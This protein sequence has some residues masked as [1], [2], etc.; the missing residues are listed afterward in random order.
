L[1]SNKRF[2]D[3]TKLSRSKELLKYYNKSCRRDPV[4]GFY[5]ITADN[6]DPIMKQIT[7]QYVQKEFILDIAYSEVQIL[8]DLPY[9][10]NS[11]TLYV[12]VTR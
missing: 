8:L 4:G 9:H 5:E 6:K 3:W 12:E 7:G 10:P 1:S 2:A 11:K